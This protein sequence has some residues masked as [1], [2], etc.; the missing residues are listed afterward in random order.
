MQAAPRLCNRSDQHTLGHAL[1]TSPQREDTTEV[2]TE[3]L[4]RVTGSPCSPNPATRPQTEVLAS[5][6]QSRLN[7]SCLCHRT[8]GRL[9]P[10]GRHPDSTRLSTSMHSGVP[11]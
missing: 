4:C 8:S 10:G 11:A 5:E 2:Q 3:G 1:L 7:Q 9:C 6:K